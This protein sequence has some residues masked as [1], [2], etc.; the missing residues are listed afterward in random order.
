[1]DGEIRNKTVLARGMLS[2]TVKLQKGLTD[3]SKCIDKCCEEKRCHVALMLG[4]LC[5]S[6]ECANENACQP[7]E[8]PK[9]II[10]KNPTIAYVK[11]GE[12]SMGNDWNF[13]LPF[14]L[15]SL[16][17]NFEVYWFF[18]ENVRFDISY[19]FPY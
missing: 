10:E 4:K 5:Y 2:G 13:F 12:I 17:H 9:S 6:M 19:Y 7:K 14:S 3:M 15:K 1:M 16:C 8:A 11:R 18:L